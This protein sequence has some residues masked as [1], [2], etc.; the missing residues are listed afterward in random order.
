[1]RRIPT[2]LRG[3]VVA[4]LTVAMAC[5]SSRSQES[6]SSSSQAVVSSNTARVLSFEQP[7]TDWTATNLNLQQ[8]N[9]FVDG[10]LSAAVTIVTSCGKLTSV[11]ECVQNIHETRASAR[12]R[13]CRV[14]QCQPR[15]FT[16]RRAAEQRKSQQGEDSLSARTREVTG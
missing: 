7:T 4:V 12:R 15:V 9:Q 5:S 2:G 1:M 14:T 13:R 11:R 16:C 3:V 8:G 6:V 10:Q